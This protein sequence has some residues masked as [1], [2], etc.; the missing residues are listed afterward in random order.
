MQPLTLATVPATLRTK[1]LAQLWRDFDVSA[2]ENLRESYERVGK[3]F[4]EGYWNALVGSFRGKELTGVAWIE[5]QPGRVAAF[6]GPILSSR[7]QATTNRQLVSLAMEHAIAL[8]VRLIQCLRRDGELAEALALL[9]HG[10][11]RVTSLL[12]MR[13]D[14]SLLSENCLWENRGKPAHFAAPGERAL[15]VPL[16]ADGSWTSSEYPATSLRFETY[17]SATRDRLAAI[18]EKTY[19]GSLDCPAVD[20]FRTINDVLDGYAATGVHD[21]N[22]WRIV[23]AKLSPHGALID[24]GCV[25]LAEQPLTGQWELMYMGV[26]PAARGRGWGLEIVRHAQWMAWTGGAKSLVLAVDLANEPG[27]RMYQMAGFQEFDRRELYLRGF[28]SVA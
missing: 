16:P 17:A 7:E 6:H 10:F 27:V 12:Y 8:R 20:G 1:A 22:R 28:D 26:V 14:N 23:S 25:L 5:P 18:I 24:V 2:I 13:A 9:E 11:H 21:P 15:A 3:Q 19:V 4:G